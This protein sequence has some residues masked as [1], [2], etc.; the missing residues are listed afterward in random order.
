MTPEESMIAKQVLVT[1]GR[2]VGLKLQGG[3]VEFFNCKEFGRRIEYGRHGN[4]GN[5]DQMIS[6]VTR[7]KN[8]HPP[9]KKQ[10]S[11]KIND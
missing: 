8:L 5:T 2:A 3:N 1:D 11:L 10:F 6:D 9:K 4:N 7:I